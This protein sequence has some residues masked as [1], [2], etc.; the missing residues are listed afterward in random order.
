[1]KDDDTSPDPT[2]RH[3]DNLKRVASVAT[4]RNSDEEGIDE[5]IWGVH[6]S[7]PE[8]TRRKVLKRD[9]HRCRIDGRRSYDLGGTTRVLVQRV[10]SNPSHCNP[11]DPDNLTTQCLDCARWLALKPDRRDLPPSIRTL[12]E[13]IDV[14]H[15]WIKILEYLAAN[16]PA[17][18]GEITDNAP[19][20]S[21]VGVRN[22][23]YGLMSLDTRAEELEQPLVVKDRIDGSY[24]FSLQ[25]PDDRSARGIVPVRLSE[26]RTRLLDELVRRMYDVFDDDVDDLPERIAEI[27]DRGSYQTRLMRRRGQAFEFPFEAWDDGDWPGHPEAAVIEAIEVVAGRTNNVSRELVGHAIADLLA[28][29]SE[30]ELARTIQTWI[31][32]EGPGCPR[33]GGPNSSVY[34]GFGFAPGADTDPDGVDSDTAPGQST[35]QAVDREEADLTPPERALDDLTADETVVERAMYPH[36]EATSAEFTGTASSPIGD[37]D[38]E[39]TDD[40]HRGNESNKER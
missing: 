11:N 37:A 10:S 3:T 7:I 35:L 26:R 30:E 15:S 4:E 6:Y 1:M 36:A 27:V 18:T 8:D 14:P 17:T 22:A 38:K 29:N 5:I 12:L 40:E 16:G 19:L 31:D 39:E 32:G 21:K 34:P 25:I 24:G 9:N 23:L 33:D 13:D 20:T 2:D 28:N